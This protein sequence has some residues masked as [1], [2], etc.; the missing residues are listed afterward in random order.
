M[1]LPVERQVHNLREHD[2]VQYCPLVDWS[3][4]ALQW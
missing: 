4:T 3:C 2:E 1:R